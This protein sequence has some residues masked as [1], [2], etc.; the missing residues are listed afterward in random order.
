MYVGIVVQLS[1]KLQ[2]AKS[3]A[4]GIV[5]ERQYLLELKQ[6]GNNMSASIHA[7]ARGVVSLYQRMRSVGINI[8]KHV[9]EAASR[10]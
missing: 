5:L 2:C 9:P 6:N 1:A 8:R 10:T 7:T 4:A 3:N